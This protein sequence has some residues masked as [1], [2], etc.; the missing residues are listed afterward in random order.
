[1]RGYC[2]RGNA[3]NVFQVLDAIELSGDL[4]SVG[5]QNQG[6]I[7]FAARVLDQIDDLL[8]MPRIDIGRRFVCQQEFWA[9]C[10]RAGDSDTL[11]FADRKLRR[12][13]MQPV[14]EAD[15]LEQLLGPIW[16]RATR[17][18]GHSK[19]HI[20]QSREARQQIK[21]LKDVT[22]LVGSKTVAASF[23]KA[24][25]VV[26]IDMDRAGIGPSDAGN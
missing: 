22:N 25:N 13:M 11:L 6:D 18:E 8:L 4:G 2:S 19:Q 9:I 10:Q 20:L 12:T 1:M 7:F 23:G 15:P 5:H 21:S 14:T 17:G 3:I 26:P 16:L 24:G